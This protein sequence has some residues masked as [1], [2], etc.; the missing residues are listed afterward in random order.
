MV[1]MIGL[2]DRRNDLTLQQFSHHWR[3]THRELALRLVP[4]GLMRG[5]IQDHR[6]DIPIEG[7]QPPTDGCPE[8]WLDNVGEFERLQNSPEYLEGAHPDETNFMNGAARMMATDETVVIPGPGRLNMGDAVKVMLFF[9][10]NVAMSAADFA[11]W[12]DLSHPLLM[13]DAKP[14]RLARETP[15]ADPGFADLQAYD[16][17][18]ASWWPDADSFAATW[19][20]RSDG[21]AKQWID[22]TATT[23]ML[24]SEEFVVNP[25]TQD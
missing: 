18:E 3:T 24:V 21:I 19:K 7:V 6:L 17:M 8:V 23:G 11:A 25:P 12:V 10:R 16:G 14:L 1:K 13:P 15:I 2:L 9:K 20:G 22:P 4:P 5:Y